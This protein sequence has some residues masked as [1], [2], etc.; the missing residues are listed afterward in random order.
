MLQDYD[1][2][3]HPPQNLA[4]VNTVVLIVGEVFEGRYGWDKGAATILMVPL[5]CAIF[6]GLHCGTSAARY[7]EPESAA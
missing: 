3:T 1:A 7:A 2:I 4:K 6:C 5:G